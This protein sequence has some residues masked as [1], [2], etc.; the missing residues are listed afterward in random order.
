MKIYKS[1]ILKK[2]GVIILHRHKDE[3]NQFIN[4]LN[5]VEEKK[6]GNSKIIFLSLF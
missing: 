4:E 5:I 2:N 3:N 6:Y 1:N